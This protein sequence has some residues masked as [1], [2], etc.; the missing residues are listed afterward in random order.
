MRYSLLKAPIAALS[1]TALLSGCVLG[2]FDASK[3]FVQSYDGYRLLSEEPI[4]EYSAKPTGSVSYTGGILV[5]NQPTVTFAKPIGLAGEPVLIGVDY[6][7]AKMDVD[8]A[9]DDNTAEFEVSNFQRVSAPISIFTDPNSVPNAAVIGLEADNVVLGDKFDGKLSGSG[10]VYAYKPT[11]TIVSS[12]MQGTLTTGSGES[13][14]SYG[15]S[16]GVELLLRGTVGSEFL[17][18]EASLN[19]RGTEGSVV[20]NEQLSIELPPELPSQN[21]RYYGAG[22]AVRK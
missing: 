21:E 14:Q 1:A 3:S 16:L 2:N 20:P 19:L 8:V 15:A 10:G 4:V 11:G 9:F 17:L 6:I 18:G 5:E 7:V 22:Y 12:G 13:L